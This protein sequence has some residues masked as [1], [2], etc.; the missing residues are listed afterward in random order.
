MFAAAALLFVHVCA[1]LQVAARG[2]TR[3][4]AQAVRPE[5]A[6][7]ISGTIRDGAGGV[8]A[9]ASIVIRNGARDQFTVTGPDGRFSVPAPPAGEVLLIVRAAGFAELRYTVAAGAPR[10]NVD[11]VVVPATV[12]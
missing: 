1:S 3:G 8:I 9:G 12:T 6:S 10:A 7:P 4:G 5:I 11:L 2:D